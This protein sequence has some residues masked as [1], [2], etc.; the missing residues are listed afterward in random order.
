[1]GRNDAM[2]TAVRCQQPSPTH[3]LKGGKQRMHRHPLPINRF[4]HS[5]IERRFSL[6]FLCDQCLAVPTSIA[7][8]LDH[9]PAPHS[10]LQF[11][12]IL[13]P[14]HWFGIC[15][16]SSLDHAKIPLAECQEDGNDCIEIVP[17]AGRFVSARSAKEQ[18]G[19]A[20]NDLSSSETRSSF[21]CRH[22]Q[23]YNGRP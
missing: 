21:Q 8:T 12:F 1:M 11:P 23:R 22:R 15:A 20:L 10:W 19:L 13:I 3:L 9:L 5:F 6:A 2:M 16:F 18:V 4:S 14:H 17:A 7:Q